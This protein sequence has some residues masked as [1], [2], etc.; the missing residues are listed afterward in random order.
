MPSVVYST[1]C[2]VKNDRYRVS[3]V[4][5]DDRNSSK[6]DSAPFTANN[7]PIQQIRPAVTQVNFECINED[8]RSTT[9][10]PKSLMLNYILKVHQSQV[11]W[12]NNLKKVSASMDAINDCSLPNPALDQGQQ[13]SQATL[14]TVLSEVDTPQIPQ[15]RSFARFFSTQSNV[16]NQTVTKMKSS[17]KLSYVDVSNSIRWNVKR[18]E[19][20]FETEALAN[21]LHAN[22]TLCLATL[23]QRPTRLLVFVNPLCGKGE[24]N[25][26][27][28][29]ADTIFRPSSS[30]RLESSPRRDESS[31]D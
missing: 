23:T 13:D 3:I 9:I 16:D 26:F 17:I 5:G 2:S 22:L 12:K 15:Q 27:Q 25:Y 18:L 11:I 19:L 6:A 28:G 29:L 31:F 4:A 14:S 30:R 10:L 7:I 8:K 21:E 20:E 1:T 24:K